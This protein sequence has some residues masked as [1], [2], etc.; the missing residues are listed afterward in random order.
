MVLLD[1]LE[2]SIVREARKDV[3]LEGEWDSRDDLSLK[4][5][6]ID[7]SANSLRI[8]LEIDSPEEL[9]SSPDFKDF[10]EVTFWG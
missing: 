8:Q 6:F 3:G 9:G 2:I 1:A 5:H 7:F 4:W 10:V